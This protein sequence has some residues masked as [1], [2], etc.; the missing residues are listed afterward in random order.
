LHEKPTTTR[1]AHVLP[2]LALVVANEPARAA[3]DSLGVTSLDPASIP[4]LDARVIIPNFGEFVIR[5][6]RERAPN[7]TAAFLSLAARDAFDGLAF[8]RTVPGYLVQT[9]DPA[10]KDDD[11][12]NDGAAV[13]PWRLAADASPP[14]HRRGTV[15]FAWR[16]D[17]PAT[18]GMEWFVL[19]ADVASL[20]ARASAFGEVVEGL[21]VV[22][23][24]SQVSTFRNRRPLAP[25][26]IAEVR[27]EKP[28]DAQ[29]PA[30][31]DTSK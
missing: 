26:R 11:P 22:D 10:S 4:A 5:L 23:R 21:D 13:P 31:A 20:D 17:R 12:A 30:P 7:A 27:L 16:G 1:L 15:S 25:V 9:G 19:L 8:H 14:L 3:P 2:I 18:A 29:G 6:D 24:V 28:R